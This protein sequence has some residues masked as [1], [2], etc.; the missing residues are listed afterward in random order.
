M[1]ILGLTYH[2]WL[3]KLHTPEHNIEPDDVQVLALEILTSTRG[4]ILAALINNLAHTVGPPLQIISDHGSDLKK[5]IELYLQEHPTTIY[6]YDF[7]HQVAL[8]LK[9]QL[10][11]HQKFQDFLDLCNLTRSQI[12]QTELSFLMPP[13]QR[14]KARYH[15]LDLLVNW[16]L[17]VLDYWSKQD[18][19][20][21]S[22]QFILDWQTLSLLS[23]KI[24]LHTLSLLIQHYGFF[25]EDLML[26]HQFLSERLAIQENIDLIINAANLGRRRFLSKLGWLLDY[27]LELQIIADILQ[28]FSLAKMHLN[29]CGLHPDSPQE[30]LDL[31]Q[32]FTDSTAEIQAAQQV[33]QYLITSTVQIPHHLTLPVTSD[34]IESFFSKYKTFSDSAPYSEINEMVL[35]LLLSPRQLTAHNI[36]QALETIDLTTLNTWIQQV[37]GPSLLS[38]RKQAFA[39]P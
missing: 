36:L 37:F 39:P 35:S 28:V 25:A 18:F 38:K 26:F 2:T 30:W 7:T 11:D 16:G 32:H 19:S 14:T 21:I 15:N 13:T 31:S 1:L 20:L 4:E 23:G 3:E 6:T 10:S 33:T 22:S 34:I 5:G 12:Q 17:Q 27:Q 8:W 29:L 24:S 9:Y